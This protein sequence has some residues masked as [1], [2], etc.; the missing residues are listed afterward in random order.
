VYIEV[1]SPNLES[2]CL[3]LDV[4]VC[5]NTVIYT[6]LYVG[7]DMFEYSEGL[8]VWMRE[9]SIQYCLEC[10]LTVP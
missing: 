4:N 3:F 7:Q 2:R 1:L 9:R 5:V 6:E 8:R 10:Y